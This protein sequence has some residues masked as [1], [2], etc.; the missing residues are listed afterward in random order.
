MDCENEY[1]ESCNDR[2]DGYKGFTRKCEGIPLRKCHEVPTEDC[3][4]V[5]DTKC[6]L[7]PAQECHQV[8]TIECHQVPDKVKLYYFQS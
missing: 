5:E 1:V 6:D 2:K 4:T 3:V 7:V 8:N